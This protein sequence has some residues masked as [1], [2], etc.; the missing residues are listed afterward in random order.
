MTLEKGNNSLSAQGNFTVRP[1]S[2]CRFPCGRVLRKW[3]CLQPNGSPE[4]LQTLNEF[5]GGTDVEVVIAGYSQSTE[6]IS[7]LE[8]FKSL[9]INAT[10]PALDAKLLNSA[11][12]QGSSPYSFPCFY[13]RF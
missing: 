12:L 1:R 9:N 2:D 7:L 6:V 3:V 11:S 5:V 10:L 8:A 4:G 13:P